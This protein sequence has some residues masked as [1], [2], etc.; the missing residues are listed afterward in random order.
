[1]HETHEQ[2]DTTLQENFLASL[3]HAKSHDPKQTVSGNSPDLVNSHDTNLPTD[4]AVK[5]PLPSQVA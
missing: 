2:K 1:M 4:A 5:E 3:N